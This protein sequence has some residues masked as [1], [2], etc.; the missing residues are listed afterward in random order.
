MEDRPYVAFAAG[1]QSACETMAGCRAD[2]SQ[3]QLRA[4][5][6]A[7]GALAAA[8]AA[9]EVFVA[10]RFENQMAFANKLVPPPVETAE[11]D[12]ALR[13]AA[14]FLA[15]VTVDGAA[16]ASVARELAAAREVYPR[17]VRS[18]YAM[19]EAFEGRVDS[20]ELLT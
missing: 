12:I 3:R 19:Q 4:F 18:L 6:A 17:L 16:F 7:Q 2:C 13:A 20:P 5:A 1:L 10:A 11:L 15:A 8:A 14:E 9:A